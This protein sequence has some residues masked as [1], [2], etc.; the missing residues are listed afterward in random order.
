M[1]KHYYTSEE[2]EDIRS[3]FHKVFEFRKQFKKTSL[4][5]E[6]VIS[7]FLAGNFKPG[8]ENDPLLDCFGT[9]VYKYKF[10]NA[11]PK[12]INNMNNLPH[13]MDAEVV[14][15]APAT[16]N[17]AVIEGSYSTFTFN[18]KPSSK[19]PGRAIVFGSWNRGDASY[20]FKY[21]TKIENAGDAVLY[22]K[23]TPIATLLDY[24]A[25]FNIEIEETEE[26]KK[27]I[28]NI[29]FTPQEVE[30][31]GQLYE[32]ESVSKE[33]NI[34]DIESIKEILNE[35][36]DN[37]ASYVEMIENIASAP[38]NTCREVTINKGGKNKFVYIATSSPEVVGSLIKLTGN[39][40]SE[41]TW[42][43]VDDIKTISEHIITDDDINDMSSVVYDLNLVDNNEG[44]EES[45][46]STTSDE[47]PTDAPADV[48]TEKEAE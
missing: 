37:I 1:L 4:N 26:S 18:A 16:N 43:S 36:D 17:N 9:A 5:E 22:N 45:E 21:V 40:T 48:E 24:L 29:T 47:I 7:N 19:K 38:K 14:N 3:N 20:S 2:I 8:S 42:T 39:L 28:Y 32:I 13:I 31:Y 34:L 23:L 44:E 12:R 15:A 11:V 41:D 25:H 6:E 30:T 46:E 27:G 33:V 35:I 10:T